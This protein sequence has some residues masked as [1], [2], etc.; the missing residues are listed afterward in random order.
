MTSDIVML[1]GLNG[2]IP[3]IYYKLNEGVDACL[4]F[5]FLDS[6]NIHAEA[7]VTEMLPKSLLGI[8]RIRRI[9]TMKR[10][11][12][13]VLLSVMLVIATICVS[14][15]P[16]RAVEPD[17]EMTQEEMWYASENS[18]T[19]TEELEEETE[20]TT[21]VLTEEVTEATTEEL[22]E[23]TTEDD[24]KASENIA[25]TETDADTETAG[26]IEDSETSVENGNEDMMLPDEEATEEVQEEIAEEMLEGAEVDKLENVDIR[27]YPEGDNNSFTFDNGSIVAGKER[28]YGISID[29]KNKFDVY[30]Y[31]LTAYVTDEKGNKYD[32]PVFVKWRGI[33][34]ARYVTRDITND[35]K[36]YLGYNNENVL[37]DEKV[38]PNNVGHDG[39]YYYHCDITVPEQLNKGGWSFH[40]YAEVVRLDDTSGKVV[41]SYST[42][43][44]D[45]IY[46]ENN[47]YINEYGNTGDLENVDI[48][49]Y[50][51]GKYLIAGTETSFYIQISNNNDF[52]I[53][54]DLLEM[55]YIFGESK[56][57]E[58][59][60]T[61]KDDGFVD[62]IRSKSPAQIIDSN[63]KNILNNAY[64]S[65]V[66]YDCE[67]SDMDSAL[68]KAGETV[69]YRVDFILD[70]K[71]YLN[72][73]GDGNFGVFGFRIVLTSEN[74]A[75]NHYDKFYTF[76]G[77]SPAV[78]VDKE[79]ETVPNMKLDSDA[80][81]VLINSAFTELEIN[82]GKHLKVDLIIAAVAEASVEQNDLEAIKATAK[83]RK[84]AV[85]LDMNLV[86]FID[87]IISGNVNQLDK[88]IT[89][90][91]DVP[92]EFQAA[93]RKF[94]I[95]RL[96]DGIAE[97]LPDLDDNPNTV[98]FSTGKFSL[99]ALIYEDVE[100][101][102]TEPSKSDAPE[103]VVTPAQKDN[104]TQ[105]QT[106][107]PNTG[108]STPIAVVFILMLVSAFL[109]VISVKH[110]KKNK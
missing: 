23:V 107:S 81:E 28:E 63:G 104:N 47:Y 37:I 79:D 105:Q 89:M 10:R 45:D 9:D 42:Y 4:S 82:S 61:T 88:E 58:D 13:S 94:S 8:M 44:V 18:E 24:E 31:C 5:S 69:T 14:N 1:L 41:A 11:M 103:T 36:G 90:T 6:R 72:D 97:E 20:A 74:G 39:V 29:N 71:S 32:V 34:D 96:H 77:Y 16:S 22:T 15:M 100:G 93:N 75:R 108:D 2:Q 85:I 86:R 87:G 49:I 60:P 30:L 73:K 92:K 46:I 65:T 27:I 62:W 80:Y 53:N 70:S 21:E 25:S 48:N 52:D 95:I 12:L 19:T 101:I 50:Q 98:T 17:D 56:W 55:P 67:I 54:L 59:Y 91:I 26:E 99:Y 40:V 64:G 78:S 68:I 109:A 7:S 33:K 38:S 66:G 3:Y 110:I 57:G 83:K 102:T 106:A 35:T 84:I 51:D 76:A 43:E